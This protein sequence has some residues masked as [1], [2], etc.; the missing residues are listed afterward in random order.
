M[1]K[2]DRVENLVI[3]HTCV[4]EYDREWFWIILVRS[5]PILLTIL[6]RIKRIVKTVEETIYFR[7][8]GVVG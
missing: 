4:T 8:F 5:R 3:L 7:H 1:E 6:L 2:L